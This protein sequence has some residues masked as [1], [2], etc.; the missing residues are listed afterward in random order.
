[1]TV[2]SCEVLDFPVSDHSLIRFDISAAPPPPI[3]TTHR[4]RRL[5][6]PSTAEDFTTA[7]SA[8]NITS[9][10]EVTPHLSP[11]FL[12]SSFDITCSRIMDSVAPYRVK[13]ANGSSD[14]WLSEVT[15]TLRRQCRQAERKWRRDRLHVSLEVF[16]D[17]LVIY[18]RAVKEAKSQ[19]LSKLINNNSHRPGILFSTIN[20]V[21]NPA[22]VVLN[23]AS[24]NTCNVFKKYFIDKVQSVRQTIIPA[25]VV[26]VPSQ[27]TQ[28]VLENFELVSVVDLKKAVHDLKPTS[29]PLDTVP[30]RI[31][32][33]A[34]DIVC[35]FLV[36]F[37]NSCFSLGVV[38]N[39]LK[40]AIVRPLLKKPNLDPL[41]L[42]NFRP[43]SH[44]SFLAKLMEK[45]VF[46]QLQS[47]LDL[48]G[49]GDK[50]QSGFKSRHSTESALLRVH[51]DIL[52]AMDNK[53]S[54]VMVLL[55]LTAAF[56]TVDHAI[57]IDRLQHVVGLQ[58]TVLKWFSSYLTNRTFSV[59]I[60]DFSSSA[61]PL[62]SGVP[63][64][65][66]LGPLL[67]SLYML[68]LGQLISKHKVQFHFYADDLQVYLPVV[69]NNHSALDP[70]HNCIQD[71]KRWLSQNFLHLNEGKTEYILF[72]PDSPCSSLNFGPLTPQFASTVRNLG[73]ALDNR[74]HFDKQIGAVVK[75]SFFQLR[76]LSKVKS[77]LSRADLE[78]AIHAFIS[79]RL[80]YCNALYTG[81]NQS[82]LNRLQMVQNAAARL[83]TNVH[84]HT[85]ITP[86]L[87]SLH[88]LPV[89][90]RVEYKVLMFVFKAINGLSPAYLSELL[91]IYQPARTLRSSQSTS[92][93]IPKCR[94]KKFGGRSFAIQGPTLWNALP[95]TL[96][97]ITVFS[98]F[99]SQL[100]TFLF[101]K[102]FNT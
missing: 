16:R 59:M 36:S 67:F 43:I 97:N 83:L 94:Y 80:D 70:I 13:Y 9:T 102:A 75:I 6:T 61:A 55:D 68:P 65:S 53:N 95:A 87:C 82:L 96:R 52:R 42:S 48:H 2:S 98:V 32:K 88:W 26:I 69:L 93:I 45:L 89:R 40:H 4:R 100:K 30:A 17:C 85:H 101:R 8:S 71:I 15:W 84:K 50:F 44:L 79:S 60:D 90:Y 10:V 3:S 28:C 73:V 22:P 47:Y 24:V 78:R 37:M 86:V 38:P 34:I 77:F 54:V 20:S 58:G 57:L 72:T 39:P 7:F 63:Q 41:V 99:K 11:E 21:I 76:L 29:C 27:A 31:L 81:L 12:L 19:Y 5:I 49:M 18:Q 64:G 23:D 46:S 92:L 25:P 14:P 74:L 56:D 66:I 35:P 51:N 33:E 1:M 91:T 62:S